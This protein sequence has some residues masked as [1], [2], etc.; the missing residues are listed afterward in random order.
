MRGRR[1]RQRPT[2]R[3]RASEADRVLLNDMDALLG[4]CLL[5]DFKWTQ[6]SMLDLYC[7]AILRRPDLPSVRHL[8]AEHLPVLKHVRDRQARRATDATHAFRRV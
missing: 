3:V 6:Q 1:A 7:V 8:T 4:F 5:P 2:A